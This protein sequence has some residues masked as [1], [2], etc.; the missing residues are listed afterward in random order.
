MTILA[1]HFISILRTKTGLLRTHKEENTEKI[2]IA[3]LVLSI[4]LLNFA[5]EIKNKRLWQENDIL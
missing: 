2:T 3:N 5:F 4:I 1:S